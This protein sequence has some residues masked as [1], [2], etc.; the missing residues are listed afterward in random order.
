MH[1]TLPTPA[2]VYKT[3]DHVF[4]A[5][6][7]TE[8]RGAVSRKFNICVGEISRGVSRTWPAGSGFICARSFGALCAA[9]KRR[10]CIRLFARRICRCRC[11]RDGRRARDDALTS[12]E[13]ATGT[14]TL[15]ACVARGRAHGTG[16]LRAV[17]RRDEVTRLFVTYPR[18]PICHLIKMA[19]KE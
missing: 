7:I 19:R 17:V 4:I 2:S 1:A 11:K 8:R 15:F 9:R 6:F 12:R 5:C 18:F 13:A 10:L 3:F 14:T 16:V